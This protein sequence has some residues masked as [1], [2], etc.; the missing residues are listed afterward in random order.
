MKLRRLSEDRYAAVGR[1]SLEI[2]RQADE[3]WRVY[4]NGEPVGGEYRRRRD[5]ARELAD[6]ELKRSTST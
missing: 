5:A 1:E 3:T 2:R 6:R 4:C